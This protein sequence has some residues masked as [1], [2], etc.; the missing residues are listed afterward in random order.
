MLSS[1]WVVSYLALGL[2][3]V[4][5][6]YVVVHGGGLLTSAR[7][8]A[9]AVM[10]LAIVAMLGLARRPRRQRAA[11]TP[12]GPARTGALAA[13]QALVG[14]GGRGSKVVALRVDL[15]ARRHDLVDPVEDGLVQ[16][17]VRAGQQA[18]KLL[19][20]ARPARS[21]SQP[22]LGGP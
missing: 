22:L 10:V 13:A 4:L 2:P 8:Y 11:I 12:G 16:F 18:V 3:G 15:R 21:D 14:D 7:E 19:G 20:S 1:L 5:A 6:G 17:R 9:V